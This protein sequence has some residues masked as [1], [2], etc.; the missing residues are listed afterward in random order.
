MVKSFSFVTIDNIS[1][2][3]NKD[4]MDSLFKDVIAKYIKK[5]CKSNLFEYFTDN[6]DSGL[7]KKVKEYLGIKDK[8]ICEYI[9]VSGNVSVKCFISIGSV[10]EYI[11]IRYSEI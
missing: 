11:F 2:N 7:G 3:S 4:I 8:I 5:E 1:K 10:I 9:G 6:F